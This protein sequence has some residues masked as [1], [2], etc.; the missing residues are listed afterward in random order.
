MRA[1]EAIEAAAVEP[2]TPIASLSLNGSPGAKQSPEIIVR[3]FFFAIDDATRLAYA[4]VFSD[5]QAATAVA[6]LRRA[7]AFFE[8]TASPLSA[9]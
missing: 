3:I 6:F 1:G 8:L 9:C 2:G 4:E 5:Q 7:I